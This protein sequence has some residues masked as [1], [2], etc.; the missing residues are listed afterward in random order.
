MALAVAAVGLFVVR[1]LHR[2]AD[3]LDDLFLAQTRYL[4]E[5]PTRYVDLAIFAAAA[6]SLFLELSVIRWQGTVFEFFAFYKNFTLL[7]CFAGLGLGYSL[8]SR[9]RTPLAAVIPLLVWQCMFLI[10]FR[11]GMS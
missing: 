7:S 3:T 10:A 6:M 8:A 2:S 1:A 9:D 5:L 4:D 11:F